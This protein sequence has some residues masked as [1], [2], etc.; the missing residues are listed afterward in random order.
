MAFWSFNLPSGCLRYP[1]LRGGNRHLHRTLKGWQRQESLLA[2]RCEVRRKSFLFLK[3]QK[4]STM[5]LF[6]NKQIRMFLIL[7]D[8]RAQDT[9]S[10]F[11]WVFFGLAMKIRTSFI[12]LLPYCFPIWKQLGGCSSWG[13]A[14]NSLPQVL[15]RSYSLQWSWT[16]GRR[17]GRW[18]SGP[19]LVLSISLRW[20]Q[21][22]FFVDVLKGF[23]WVFTHGQVIAGF[24]SRLCW[25][26]TVMSCMCNERNQHHANW[27]QHV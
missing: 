21:T 9:R 17:V 20:N 6:E 22:S 10:V 2:E 23:S 13:D 8:E 4:C 7:L 11:V 3:P 1:G 26:A 25:D 5:S 24:V 14:E 12:W 15:I 18:R 27:K 16:E 19:K